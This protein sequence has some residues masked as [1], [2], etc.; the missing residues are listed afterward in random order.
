MGDLNSITNYDSEKLTEGL[1][2]PFRLPFALTKGDVDRAQMEERRK[3]WDSS[4]TVEWFKSHG[5]TLYRRVLNEVGDYTSR[6][7]PSLPCSDVETAHHPYAYYD[8]EIIND[9]TTPLASFEF[10]G[11]VA[12]AQD[13]RHRHV[14][15][16]IV[17]DGT[18]EYRILR[19]L[20]EQ[21]LDVLEANCIL[22]VL[23]LLPIEGFWFAVMPR[24][25][26][27]ITY[28]PLTKIYEV[29]DIIHSLL[30]GLSFLHG[31][32][33]SHGDVKLDNVLVN[34]FADASRPEDNNVRPKLRAKR[35]LSYGIFD[36]DYSLVLPPGMDPETFR[37]PYQ[38]SWGTFNTTMD[39][40]Q[41]EFDFNPF[42]LDVGA[43][44]VEFCT[45]FQHLCGQ[46][47]FLAPLLDKMTTRI[48]GNRFTASEALDYFNKMY[49]QLTDAELQQPV[50]EKESED[51]APYYLYDRWASVPPD[52]AQN[53]A[54]F[55]EPPIPWTTRALRRICQR[56]W[57][58][59]VVAYVRWL[60]FR[61]GLSG[62]CAPT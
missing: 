30:K 22:P 24:W 55:K 23:E 11:K 48:L 54:H 26:S 21:P 37:L 43:L 8:S 10:A 60:F 57:R 41:G 3:F 13:S 20:S 33:I 61:L 14:A 39:T 17:Q 36:F 5:Y 2:K 35:L 59:H 16:K 56:E 27:A 9:F 51:F 29:L 31:H 42:V 19:F 25:G 52:F 49:A 44:G 50:R 53:W 34:H 12:F 15:I 58:F 6:T 18:D 47:P 32:N 1:T 38:R 40:A 45:E 62:T 4:E 46:V 7:V 28:P